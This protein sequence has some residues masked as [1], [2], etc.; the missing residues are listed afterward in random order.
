MSLI[1]VL[2]DFEF[3]YE[4]DNKEDEDNDEIKTITVHGMQAIA[5]TND[6]FHAG[7]ENKMDK[8]V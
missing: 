1:M 2:D 8:R 6:L 7:G 4:L 5:F 3:V